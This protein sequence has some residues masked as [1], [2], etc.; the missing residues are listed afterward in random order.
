MI[1][2]EWVYLTTPFTTFQMWRLENCL[3][4]V[5]RYL[6]ILTAA[7]IQPILITFQLNSSCLQWTFIDLALCWELS[8]PHQMYAKWKGNCFHLSSWL[9]AIVAYV[10]YLHAWFLFVCSSLFFIYSYSELFGNGKN[11]NRSIST[12]YKEKNKNRYQLSERVQRK[13]K[14]KTSDSYRKSTFQTIL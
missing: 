13:N 5:L 10:N 11:E 8:I 6:C 14:T 4:F 9:C 2:S 12:K 1:K 3:P 7:P